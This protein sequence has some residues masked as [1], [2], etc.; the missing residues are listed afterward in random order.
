MKTNRYIFLASIL[1]AFTA[2]VHTIVGTSEIHAPILSSSLPESISLL[3]YACW[4]L[5]TVT[6]IL[7]SIALFWSSRPSRIEGNYVLPAFIGVLWVIFGLVFIFVAL[8][9]SGMPALAV[10]PQWVLLVPTGVLA[11]FG[12]REEV[13]KY[14]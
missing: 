13:A 3:L 7:S 10:L 2:C 1:S 6:L 8:C 12:A 11:I 5:V 14:K 9:F 4:H